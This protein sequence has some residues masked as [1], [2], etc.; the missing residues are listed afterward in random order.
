LQQDTSIKS[1]IRG[2]RLQAGWNEE[3]LEG[4]L[5]GFTAV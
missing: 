4:I 5:C 3:I 1:S 2:K